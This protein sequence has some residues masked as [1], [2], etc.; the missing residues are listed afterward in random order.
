MVKVI[1]EYQ[2]LWTVKDRGSQHWD[3]LGR[4]SEHEDCLTEIR[5]FSNNC[6]TMLD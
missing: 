1:K 5:T 3:R 2:S 4:R 6:A